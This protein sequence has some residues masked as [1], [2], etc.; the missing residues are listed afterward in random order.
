MKFKIVISLILISFS[1]N[2]KDQSFHRKN[3][4]KKLIEKISN[5]PYPKY[6]NSI[7]IKAKQLRKRYRRAKTFSDKNKII[8][9]SKHFIHQS[10]NELSI[11]WLGTTWDFNGISKTPGKGKIAC[12]YFVSN[13]L[14]DCGFQFHR[15]R[16]S[17]QPALKIIKS[18]VD[19]RHIHH[20]SNLS[21]IEFSKRF[22]K[23]EDGIYIVGLDYHVGLLSKKGSKSVF[24]HSSYYNPPLSVTRESLRDKTPLSDSK[25]R[26]IGN[27]LNHRTIKR[28]LLN[29]K[30]RVSK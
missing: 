8:N 14:L 2:P 19:T 10:I 17:Q 9:E 12:G 13:L 24:I 27:V 18:F 6:L 20:Y 7:Q 1:C 21:I 3:Q 11:Y 16:M 30:I 22:K 28:W 23:L 5:I 15:V 26:V 4:D 25:Y 29:K